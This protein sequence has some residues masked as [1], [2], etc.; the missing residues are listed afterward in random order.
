MA[1]TPSTPRTSGSDDAERGAILARLSA[2]SLPLMWSLRQRAMQVYEPLGV[3]PT[4]V[5]LME[6]VDRGIDR[7][8]QIAEVL[9]AVPPAVTAMV[10]ELMQKGWLARERDESDR[11]RVHLLLTPSG[12]DALTELRRAWHDAE[13]ADLERVD[14]EALRTVLNVFETLLGARP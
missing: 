11:R 12:R 4:R 8:T 7:P 1:H 9:E 2:V 14:T 10:N 6:L 5:L 3:R 13:R